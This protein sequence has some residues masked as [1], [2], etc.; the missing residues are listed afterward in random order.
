MEYDE[1]STEIEPLECF[2]DYDEARDLF[3]DYVKELQ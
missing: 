1:I 2:D 3:N